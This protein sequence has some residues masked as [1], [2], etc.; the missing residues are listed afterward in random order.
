MP[1][2]VDE[3][4]DAED[5]AVI[6]TMIFLKDSKQIQ[7]AV[8]QRLQELTR[9]NEQGMFKSQRGGKDQILVKSQVPWPQN[10]VLAGTAKSRV[11]YDSLSTFQWISGFCSIIR[12][13][14]DTKIKNA[15]LDYLTDIIEDAQDFGWPAAKCAHALILCRMEEGKV[16]WLMSD[17]LD[18]LRRAH[19]QKVMTNPSKA[20]WTVKVYPV[21]SFKQVNAL[22]SLTTLLVTSYIDTSAVFLYL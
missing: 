19:P 21:N 22:I 18:R 2:K 12:G 15:M 10:Y 3:E 4:S 17:K 1:A 9:I 13:E 11:T 16:N 5:D 7:T 8:D 14:N 20:K 6:P